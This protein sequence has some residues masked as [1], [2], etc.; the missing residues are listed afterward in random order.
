MDD[1]RAYLVGRLLRILVLAVALWVAIEA[2]DLRGP[3]P[4]VPRHV[5][6]NPTEHAPGPRGCAP[7]C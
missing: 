5:V 7:F 3:D 2:L 1:A 4:E 6:D